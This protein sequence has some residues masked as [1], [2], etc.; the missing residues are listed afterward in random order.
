M[1]IIIGALNEE[2]TPIKNLIIITFLNIAMDNILFAS[3]KFL[4]NCNIGKKHL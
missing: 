4:N 2:K 1:V 3:N